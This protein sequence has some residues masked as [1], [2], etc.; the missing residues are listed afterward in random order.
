[1]I[2]VS[3]DNEGKLTG[4]ILARWETL[5]SDADIS[6][7][8]VNLLREVNVSMNDG[9]SQIFDINE[10]RDKGLSIEEI[11]KLLEDFIDQYD[12][13]I[14]SLDFHLNIEELASDIDKKTKRLLG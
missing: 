10:L 12:E 1:M 9:T 5:L 14:D 4:E 7:I 13:E 2:S 6:S 3:E 11:E 8:P